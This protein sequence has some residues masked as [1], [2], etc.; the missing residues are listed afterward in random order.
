LF[1]E[2]FLASDVSERGLTMEE[3]ID[4]QAKSPDIGFGPIDV[5]DISFGRH[6]E[7]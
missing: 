1:F 4:D 6:V 5:V 2:F 7:G 3:F